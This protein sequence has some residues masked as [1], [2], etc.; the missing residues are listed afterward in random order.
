MPVSNDNKEIDL[1]HLLIKILNALKA[2]FWLI[3]ITFVGGCLLGFGYFKTAR[4]VYSSEMIISSTILTDAYSIVLFENANKHLSEGD[5]TLLSKEFNIPEEAFKSLASVK[6][7]NLSETN[8]S[9]ERDRFLITADVFDQS[10]FPQVQQG[11]I[12]YLEENEFARIREDQ[13]KNTLKQMIAKVDIEIKDMEKLKERIS[14]G[15]F[16]Q[17]TKGSVMFDPTTVNSKILELTEKKLDYENKL[18]LSNSVQVIE[19]F[20]QFQRQSKPRLSASIGFG[21]LAGL[22][23]GIGIIVTRALIILMNEEEYQ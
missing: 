8:E 16:F 11:L 23:I 19:G 15:E 20:T 5:L 14:N 21:A 2:N 13:M 10:V 4:K 3:V 6:I 12:T 18:Q 7:K 9:K 22:L 1:L 17:A